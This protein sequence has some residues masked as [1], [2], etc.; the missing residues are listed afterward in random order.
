MSQIPDMTDAEYGDDIRYPAER[1]GRGPGTQAKKP[2]SRLKPNLHRPIQRLACHPHCD[3]D[4]Y[5]ATPR[6][7]LANSQAEE[8]GGI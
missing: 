2:E 7:I 8:R 6:L 5:L 1:C 4:K 3:A